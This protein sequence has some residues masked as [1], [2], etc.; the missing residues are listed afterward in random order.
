M[1]CGLDFLYAGPLF[2]HQ[3]SHV[4]ID[5]RAIQDEY[6]RA[7]GPCHAGVRQRGTVYAMEMVL[8]P[9]LAIDPAWNVFCVRMNISTLVRLA[10][11]IQIPYLAR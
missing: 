8:F 11:A 10:R 2:I 7:K 1:L 4:W 3:L 9:V 5:F 6:M